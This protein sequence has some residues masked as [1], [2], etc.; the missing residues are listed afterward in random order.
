M[1]GGA[2]GTSLRLAGCSTAVLADEVL[3]IWGVGGA[4]ESVRAEMGVLWRDRDEE[5]RR[6][7]NGAAL[8]P[9]LFLLP[10]M[11]AHR[12]TRGAVQSVVES[13][14]L[15]QWDST[16]RK[17][18]ALIPILIGGLSIPPTTISHQATGATSLSFHNFLRRIYLVHLLAIAICLT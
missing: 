7:R 16:P 17:Q 13:R 5:R 2:G 4:V 1:V 11:R 15:R 14:K 3:G 6:S 18:S 12:N 8:A 9:P 10:A